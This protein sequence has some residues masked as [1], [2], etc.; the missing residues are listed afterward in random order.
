MTSYTDA[1]GSTATTTYDL[2]GRVA[3]SDDGKGTR[4]Y[5]YDGGSER[6]GLVTS[7]ADS[8][9]GTFSSGVYDSNGALIS[10]TWPNGVV[11]A[12]AHDET[13]DPS[14]LTYTMV[15]CGQTDCTLYEENAQR[16]G[17]TGSIPPATARASR[18]TPPRL[19]AAARRQREPR[20]RRRT[21]PPIGSRRA[22]SS[23]TFSAGL[24]PCQP[25]PPVLP[26]AATCP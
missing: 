16:S 6:R 1:D 4:T 12:T 23:T 22:G 8:Q 25:H 21:T 3:T 2:A 5:T 11:V 26:R 24:P 17:S 9:V 18:L 7:V 20:Q 19:M 13:G 14:G 15:G 10:Q